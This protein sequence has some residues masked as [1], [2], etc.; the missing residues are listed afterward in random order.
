MAK[1][2][3]VRD[4]FE[5][6]FYDELGRL[7]V[8]AGRVEYVLKL[9]LKSLS[10]KGFTAGMLEAEEVRH[11]S[12]LCDKV[13]ELAK[14]KL[15]DSDKEQFLKLVLEIEQL[16]KER[17][18]TIHALWTTTD[19]REPLRIRPELTRPKRSR[20]VDW[21]KTKTVPLNT[22]R[23]VRRRLEDAYSQLQ[24]QRKSWK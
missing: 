3:A 20:R 16:A 21:S 17:N 8:A 1:K 24:C 7:V 23:K 22:L 19:A 10:G 9:C 13:T 11:L 4:D 6:L 18:D 14:K 2:F 12:S 15:N 5:P